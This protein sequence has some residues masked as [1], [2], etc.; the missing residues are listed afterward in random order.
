MAN[1]DF[2]DL[3]P[4]GPSKEELHKHLNK[5]STENKVRVGETWATSQEVHEER[6]MELYTEFYTRTMKV[7]LNR[8][9]RDVVFEL[10]VSPS[11]RK[12]ANITAMTELMAKCAELSVQH[13]LAYED[14]VK[15]LRVLAET[16][17]GNE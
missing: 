11:F 10:D 6:C 17:L 8:W 12:A 7:L 1:Q 13:V 5:M 15:G 14:K 2:W 9:L 4:P 16:D 3:P